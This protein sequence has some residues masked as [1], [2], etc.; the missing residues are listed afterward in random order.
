[1]NGS[2]LCPPEGIYIS[3]TI[4]VG[5]GACIGMNRDVNMTI[6]TNKLLWHC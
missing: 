5:I 4:D 3:I 1:M 6:N 2:F